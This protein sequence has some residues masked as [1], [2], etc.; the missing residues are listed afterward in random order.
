M[1]GTIPVPYQNASEP[2]QDDPPMGAAL[3]S[4]T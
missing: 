1:S 4:R 2:E 3:F